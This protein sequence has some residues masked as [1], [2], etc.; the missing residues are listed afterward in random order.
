MCSHLGNE[1]RG[2]GHPAVIGSGPAEEPANSGATSA[3]NCAD[4]EVFVVA[5]FCDENDNTEMQGLL[6]RVTRI[7][8][9]TGCAIGIVHHAN[10]AG[11]GSVFHRTRGASAIHGFMEW[12]IGITT[13]NEDAPPR[14]RIRKMEFLTKVGCEPD[15]IYVRA[16]GGEDT[17]VIR[18]TRLQTDQ[19]AGNGV[20]GG[21]ASELQKTRSGGIQ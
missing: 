11:V 5:S 18:L 9:E 20:N 3:A 8:G 14:K 10:K 4:V 2:W 19:L 6:D 15:P 13:V 16:E 7:Q 17:G 1:R 21:M 12:G